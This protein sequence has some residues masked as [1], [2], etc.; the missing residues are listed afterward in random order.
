MRQSFP[1]EREDKRRALMGAVEEVRDVLV[2]GADE[3]EEI[4]TLPD[5]TVDALYQ[6]GLLTLKLPAELGGAEA[7]LLTQLDV[8]EAVTRIDASAGWCLM[9]GAASLGRM[10]AFLPDEAIETMFVGG[11]PPKTCG[12][13]MP[14]GESVPVD[15]GYLVTGRWSFASG[16]RH[17]QW[18][19]SNTRVA[20][21][22]G[23]APQLMSVIFPTAKAK[24]HDNWQAAGLKG[25]GS[26]DFSVSNLYVPE[27]FTLDR[28]SVQPKRG[29]AIFRMGT[30]G[31]VSLEHSAFAFGVARRALDAV[32]DLA[33]S[34]YRG[35]RAAS[36]LALR[37]SFQKS[38]GECELRLRAA[39]SLVV[40]ILEG[41]WDTLCDGGTPDVKMHVDMRSSATFATEVAVDVVTQAFRYA[42][43]EAVYQPNVLQR[44]LRDINVAA[45]HLMVSDSTYESYGKLALGLP[46][47]DPMD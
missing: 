28:A 7:D 13:A 11:R 18:V 9:I 31:F 40:E 19:S 6:S 42:G 27:A 22:D 17:S 16:I 45:Q 32:I 47:V 41:V 14:T 38:L 3:A 23:G 33:Q 21:N 44:C 24:I 46:G 29:G 35:Y 2:A 30:P 26:N 25:T 5:A 10:G 37:T 8:I 1:A 39:R 12:V 34:K 4:G 15:G 36:P 20:R 43:G